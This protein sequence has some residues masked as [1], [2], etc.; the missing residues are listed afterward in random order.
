MEIAVTAAFCLNLLVCLL[1]GYVPAV[2]W[3]STVRYAKRRETPVLYWFFMLW[4]TV[5]T[6][7]VVWLLVV[8]SRAAAPVRTAVEAAAAPGL[9]L[10][11]VAFCIAAYAYDRRRRAQLRADTPSALRRAS[12]GV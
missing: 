8:R 4:L 6:A 12:S 5:I 7:M 2:Q 1:T 3:G 10:A 9:A 11:F